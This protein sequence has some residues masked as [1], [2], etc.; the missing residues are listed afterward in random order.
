M[1]NQYLFS[2]LILSIVFFFACGD[3][4]S[5]KSTSKNESVKKEVKA[6]SVDSK[7]GE[8]APVPKITPI[9]KEQLEKA[10][11]MIAAADEKAIAKVDAKGKFKMLCAAC[12]GFKGD[13]NVNGAKDLTKSKVDLVSS[14]AQV[15]HGKGL[16]NP[17]KGLLKDEEIIAVCKYIETLRK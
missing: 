3:D 17:F 14:V 6:K 10:K 2:I 16:M 7:K 8:T 4:K 11:A 13:L 9:P 5:P 1:K 12:H 15:Y